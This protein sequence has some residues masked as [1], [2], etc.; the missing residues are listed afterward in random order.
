MYFGALAIGADLSSGLM[1]MKKIKES[2]KNV[3]LSFKDLRGEFHKR[4]M[5]DVFFENDQGHEIQQFV[6]SVV[7]EPNIRKEKEIKVVSRV[8]EEIVATFFLTL[9]LKY[10]L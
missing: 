4:A 5:G 3:H 1:A 10:K 7:N 8:G 6:E 2:G 9:S